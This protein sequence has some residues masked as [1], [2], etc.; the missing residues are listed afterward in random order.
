M[1]DIILEGPDKLFRHEPAHLV[2]EAFHRGCIED[3]SEMSVMIIARFDAWM[4][5]FIKDLPRKR[6]GTLK[7]GSEAKVMKGRYEELLLSA[8]ASLM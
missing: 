6:N 8:T 2:L 1:E 7:G 5:A 3:D 4:A